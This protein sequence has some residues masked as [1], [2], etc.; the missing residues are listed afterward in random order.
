MSR[1]FLLVKNAKCKVQNC[2]WAS[3]SPP[4][5]SFFIIHHSLFIYYIPH[6]NTLFNQYKADYAFYDFH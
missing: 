6:P 4:N 2:G 1:T 5:Y 3:P